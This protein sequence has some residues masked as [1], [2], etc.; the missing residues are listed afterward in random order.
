[1]KEGMK[2]GMK[3]EGE[4][5]GNAPC[6]YVQVSCWS[7]LFY[8]P[9]AMVMRNLNWR[10]FVIFYRYF[11]YYFIVFL[12]IIIIVFIVGGSCWNK[13]L[14]KHHCCCN[15]CTHER[16]RIKENVTVMK[17]SSACFR[18]IFFSY[19]FRICGVQHI[20]YLYF[21][22]FNLSNYNNILWCWLEITHPLTPHTLSL[23]SPHSHTTNDFII[24]TW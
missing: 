8:A 10:G 2:E 1:M 20:I 14:L 21:N 11:Y 4:R 12:Y 23:P 5:E 22:V 17:R 13:L 3:K 6:F 24:T 7:Y 19:L 18:V 9:V 15:L 16:G